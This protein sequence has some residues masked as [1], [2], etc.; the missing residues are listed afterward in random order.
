MA[1]LLIRAQLDRAHA[2]AALVQSIRQQRA[3]TG[4]VDCVSGGVTQGE[5]S[6]CHR[7][8]VNNMSIVLSLPF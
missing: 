5:R 6:A 7:G 8:D 3:A 2:T 4:H 1:A